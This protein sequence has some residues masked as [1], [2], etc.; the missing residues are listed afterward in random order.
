MTNKVHFISIAQQM[1]AIAN[2]EKA[3]EMLCFLNAAPV[4][5]A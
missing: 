1:I 5:T 4:S 2:P 3:A